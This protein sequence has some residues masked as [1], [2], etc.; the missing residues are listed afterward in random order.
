MRF[1]FLFFVLIG[2]LLFVSC[3]PDRI[4]EYNYEMEEGGWS[5]DQLLNFDFEIKDTTAHYNLYINIRNSNEYLYRNIY[6]FLK[7]SAPNGKHSTDT[8]ECLL[9]GPKG[10]WLG[11]GTANLID[12]QIFY[13]RHIQF[14]VNGKYRVSI[15][16]AM[17]KPIL[18]AIQNIGFRVEKATLRK[19]KE[20]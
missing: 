19:N 4:Y 2:A 1:Q 9:A 18:E 16:Q 17:R 15:E 6:L 3:D 14:P 20:N 11:Q 8:I 7:L 5:N 13:K 12:N 10:E